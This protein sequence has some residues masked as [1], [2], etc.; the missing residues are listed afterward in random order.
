ML[1]VSIYNYMYFLFGVLF[2]SHG[3]VEF[4][5]IYK[6]EL[7]CDDFIIICSNCKG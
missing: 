5:N 3:A 7:F 1:C 2:H 6:H 4:L